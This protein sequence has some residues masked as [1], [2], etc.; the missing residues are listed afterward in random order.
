MPITPNPT[1]QQVGPEVLMGGVQTCRVELLLP[2]TT[3][4]RIF[5]K[6]AGNAKVKHDIFQGR[7]IVLSC[8]T[9]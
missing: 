1:I 5:L 6:N 7:G 4:Q 9:L 3:R 8:T 2:H